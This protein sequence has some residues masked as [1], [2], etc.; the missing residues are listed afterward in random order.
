VFSTP[1]TFFCFLS[2]G[3]EWFLFLSVSAFFVCFGNV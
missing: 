3:E 1:I 2:I